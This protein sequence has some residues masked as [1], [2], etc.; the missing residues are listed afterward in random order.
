MAPPPLHAASPLQ[1][2]YRIGLRLNSELR[3]DPETKHSGL[4]SSRRGYLRNER[5]CAAR[6]ICTSTTFTYCRFNSSP[7]CKAGYLTP[8]MTAQV[9]VPLSLVSITQSF[10][11]TNTPHKCNPSS[12]QV[13][14]GANFNLFLRG[15]MSNLITCIDSPVVPYALNAKNKCHT[16]PVGVLH[17]AVKSN[18]TGKLPDPATIMAD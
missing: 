2:W 14:H 17:S 11:F 16:S 10:H 4:A 18:M 3:R 9:T 15:S 5:F 8:A 6:S 1:S 13:T 12:I 7:H